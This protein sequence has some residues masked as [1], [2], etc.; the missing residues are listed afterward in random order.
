MDRFC[1]QGGQPLQG[2]LRIAGAKNAVLP[3]IAASLLIPHRVK[4]NNVP[5]L[6]D[7]QTMLILLTQM[8]VAFQ[9]PG[10][11]CLLINA[12]D[13]HHCM[14]PYE[15]VRT[16]R[17]SIV[18]LGPLLARYGEA[19]VSLPGG[20]AI[21]SRPID[22]HLQ[23]LSAM[24]AEIAIKQGYIHAKVPEGLHGAE[25]DLAQ[26]TVTGTENLMMAAVLAQ[27]QTILR[28]AAR[29]PEVVDLANFLNQ[30]GADISGVGSSE[31]VI[32]GVSSLSGGDYSVMPDRIETGTFLAAALITRG[33]IKLSSV[34]ANDMQTVLEVMRQAG[35][36]IHCGDDWIELKMDHRPHAVNITTAPYPGFP[37]DMQAQIMA[38]NTIAEGESG[39]TEL[40]FENRFMHVQE[41]IRLGADI[42]LDG[43][44]AYCRGVEQLIA[45]PVMATDLRA[46]AGL[47]LAGLAAKG[48]T[49]IDRVY[50]IDR[51]YVS[52]E[53]R[54]SRLGAKITRVRS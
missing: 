1:I 10:E 28:N 11:N 42:R 5:L 45:A 46:S 6:S 3:I 54:L 26:I 37:T 4:I 19:K 22:I 53:Q 34:K 16:M 17:A 20:C 38:V 40:V 31:V 13:L 30:L 14:A 32:N 8:G 18:V 15:L 35:A 29:E 48:E 52:I 23:G 7:V 36:T 21:G 25:I 43:H 51:G 2:E 41:M 47:V 24:G 12:A 50:H 27:G 33:H 49:M 39:V 44:T 9:M